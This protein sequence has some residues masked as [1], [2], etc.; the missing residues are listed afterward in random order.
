M[1]TQTFLVIPASLHRPVQ[2]SA[3]LAV[4]LLQRHKFLKSEITFTCTSLKYV[5][6]Q[7]ASRTT[8]SGDPRP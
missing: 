4:K 8:T 2:L 7:L 5:Q 3:V 1:R 6:H